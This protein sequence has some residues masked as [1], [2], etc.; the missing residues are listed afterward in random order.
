MRPPKRYG[1]VVPDPADW[2]QAAPGELEDG[3]GVPGP[4]D[5]GDRRAA[6]ATAGPVELARRLSYTQLWSLVREGHVDRVTFTPGGGPVTVVTRASAP[7]GVRSDRVGLP[8]D[9]AFL[10]HLLA[11]GVTVTSS[12]GGW[13]AHAAW[14][15]LRAAFPFAF[16]TLAVRAAYRLGTKTKRKATTTDKLNRL[17]A[18][19]AGVDFR[20]VAGLAGVK[21]E[22]MEIVSFLKNPARFIAL[23]ARSPAGVLLVGPPGTGKTL[24]ARAVAGEAGVPFYC[25]SGSEFLESLVG[26]GA[27]RVRSAFETARANAPCILFIDEFDGVGQARSEASGG[28]EGE[29]SYRGGGEGRGG[30]VRAMTSITIRASD[31]APPFKTGEGR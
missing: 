26:I 25:T 11:H 19:R 22:V 1:S 23:G 10:D 9:P 17:D 7:G 5:G 4:Y 6:P 14:I 28:N 27:S 24:L 2:P 16:L 3:F 30:T 31:V 18:G 12:R 29:K 13:P 15:L 8:Y 20:D 21:D